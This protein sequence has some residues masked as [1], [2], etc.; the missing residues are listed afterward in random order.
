MEAKKKKI[1]AHFLIIAFFIVAIIGLVLTQTQIAYAENNASDLPIDGDL[2]FSL[3]TNLDGIQEYKVSAYNRNL[4]KAIIPEEYNGIPVS[5]V[6]DNAFANCKNLTY[7]LVPL[8]IKRVGNNAF[9]FCT[10]LKSIDGMT[11]VKTFGNFVFNNC[12]SLNNLILPAKV[13]K[14]GTNV[15]KN[16]PNQIYSRKSANEMQS[17][18][19]TWADAIS[20]DNVIFDNAIVCEDININGQEGYSVKPYQSI[21]VDQDVVL[22]SYANGKNGVKP[23]LEI[24]SFAFA[25]CTFG[26][27]TIKNA[28]PEDDHLINLKS[29]AF[30]YFESNFL[31]IEVRITLNDEGVSED[32]LGD[33]IGYSTDIFSNTYIPE[34]TLP[35]NS[36]FDRFTRSMFSYSQLSTLKFTDT[37]LPNNHIAKNVT[38]IYNAAFEGIDTLQEIYIPPTVIIMGENVFDYFGSERYDKYYINI[39]F[40]VIPEGWHSRWL[41]NLNNNVEVKYT[42]ADNVFEVMLNKEYGNGG[43]DI[44]TVEYDKPMP[45]ATAPTKNNYIFM[46]YFTGRN[47]T[48]V[49]YYNADMTSAQNWNTQSNGTLYAYWKGV[50]SIIKFDKMGG[51]NGHNEITA[52]YGKPM[53]T[54]VAPSKTN[55]VF[56]GYYTD[57][58]GKGT[59]YYDAN[60]NSVRDWDKAM[61]TTLYAHWL[62]IP[63]II[64]FDQQGGVGGSEDAVAIFG[65]PMPN[66]NNYGKL[67]VPTKQN[68]I[69]Q[70]YFDQGNGQ[71]IKYYDENMQS[72]INWN[73]STE[74]TLYA[75]WKGVNCLIYLDKNGGTDGTNSLNIEFGTILPESPNVTAPKRFGH[76]FNGYYYYNNGTKI[77]IY[78]CYMKSNQRAWLENKPTTLYADWK[79]NEF[80]IS[81]LGLES[82]VKV[83]V[84]FGMPMPYKDLNINPGM[85]LIGIFTEENGYGKKYYN[86]DM[87]SANIWD[88]DTAIPLYAQIIANEYTITF[89][90][91][92]GTGGTDSIIVTYGQKL[93]QFDRP[94]RK[95]WIFQGYYTEVNGKG[96]E[97]NNQTVWDIPSS[98][99]LYAYWIQ[100]QYDFYVSNL[101]DGKGIG[102]G[103]SFKLKGG[104]TKTITAPNIEGY[105]FEKWM[106]GPQAFNGQYYTYFSDSQTITVEGICYRPIYGGNINFFDAIYKKACVAEGSLIT[107]ADGTQKPV[108]T[109][110]GNE[111]L[112]VWN[113]KTGAFDTAP[114]LFIDHDKRMNYE[115]INL[116][117]SD[118][119]TVKVISEHAFWDF[120]LNQYVFLRKDAAKYIGHWFN[121]QI[122]DDNGNM[123]WIKVR[124]TDVEVRNE[125]TSAWSPVT[126]GH[127]CY[128]VNGMLS[129]PGATEG[130]INIFDVDSDTM[131]FNEESYQEDIE[132]YGIFTYEEFA[133]F[134]PIPREIFDAFNAEYLKV[135]L[136]KGL[137]TGEQLGRLIENYSKFFV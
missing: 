74:T 46:G 73:K 106:C 76:S 115:V 61:S 108:E 29:S 6:A 24:D 64:K 13:E 12:S 105:T 82:E 128:Y 52:E 1:I 32:H 125:Y 14:L 90:K 21:L 36:E 120:D 93:P 20:Y 63:S 129:M 123:T 3:Y 130:L 10:N 39:D 62:G 78:D 59:K 67:I 8:S 114:I 110:T 117:F 50:E 72:C 58:N 95:Y 107:L 131:K 75:A 65:D 122:I 102:Q 70:G 27:L 23:I 84:T 43:D 135:S 103:Q 60:M 134:Y 38:R 11:N 35:T 41:G 40:P 2:K 132:K 28:K 85:R 113:L 136:G 66:S 4:V 37:N 69:F 49:K 42:K 9:S 109:L 16:I 30:S 88:L 97:Y 100:E 98:T 55:Y 80:D 89:N 112:L 111:Q 22:Y 83:H 7:V 17:L 45:S 101:C 86:G 57:K 99:T 53:P 5:E 44:V 118:G 33:E 133:E 119:T 26:S 48:G 91:Q 54:A 121:K 104:E 116:E 68:Y 18:N 19:E 47:G 34:I 137:I 126:Y 71:G 127:L 94:T 56:Q 25:G 87:S 31:T 124:L 77:Y 51:I 96:T 92:S 79:A 81:I 15:I